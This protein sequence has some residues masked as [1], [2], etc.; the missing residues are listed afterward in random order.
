MFLHQLV[1]VDTENEPVGKTTHMSHSTYKTH[2]T[3]CLFWANR[4]LLSLNCDT[5]AT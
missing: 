4:L 3:T 2:N 1:Q 5:C